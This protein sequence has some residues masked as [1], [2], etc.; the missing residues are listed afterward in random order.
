[1]NECDF[2]LGKVRPLYSGG[3]ILTSHLLYVDDLLIFCIGGKVSI[4]NFMLTLNR[5]KRILGQL[6][7]P[8]KSS[9]FFSS[10]MNFSQ[11]MVL[12]TLIGFVKGQWPCTYLG[13]FLM[14]VNFLFK[15]LGHCY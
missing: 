14:W 3:K 7:N 9:I 2:A 10:S 13:V 5:Y 8:H 4:G 15:F 12:R 6:V 1:M 11:R